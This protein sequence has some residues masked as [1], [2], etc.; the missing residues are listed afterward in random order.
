MEDKLNRGR[1]KWNKGRDGSIS[2][3]K[4]MKYGRQVK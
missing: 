3:R 4:S 1:D 2:K